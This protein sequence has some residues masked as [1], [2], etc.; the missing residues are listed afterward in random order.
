[1]L[2]YLKDTLMYL[3]DNTPRLIYFDFETT[4]L[5][6]YHEKIID[7]CFL[8]EPLITGKN[9][10]EIEN[11]IQNINDFHL[12]DYYFCSLVNPE[13]Q[14]PPKIIEITNITNENLV[15]K[16]NISTM[17]Q[18]IVEYISYDSPSIYL[19]AHNCHGFD[20]IFLERIMREH[21][22]DPQKY[23]IKYIDT[24]LLA[25]KLK[26]EMYSYSLKTLCKYYNIPEG[27]HRA[28]S[29]CIAMRKVYIKLLE[30]LS[31]NYFNKKYS[32]EDLVKNPHM[33]YD[34]LYY[35]K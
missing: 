31:R 26:P 16:P 35:T 32:A 21:D 8:K 29:D 23:D 5:N 2:N 18:S 17:I 22:Y 15:G 27:T 7:F 4:G 28:L 14:L 11:N 13:K 20:Q 19:L 25:K 30:T 10:S 12:N 9:E 6:P 33:V 3:F 24:L 34:Y 1:M